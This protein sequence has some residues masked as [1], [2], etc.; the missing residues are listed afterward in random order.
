M[1]L[2]GERYKLKVCAIYS[3]GQSA[4]SE[5]VIWQYEPCD[6]WGPV[7]EVTLDAA[8]EGNHLAWVFEHGHNQ[9][10]DPDGGDEPTPTP[11]DEVTVTLSYPEAIWSD[12]SGYQMLLDADATAYGNE[13]PT[14]GG[15]TTSGNAPAGL[16]DAFEYKIPANADG[17]MTTSNIVAPGNSVTIVIPAGTYDWCITNPTPGDRIWIAS[18]NGNVGGRQDDY[19]FEAGRTY[20][21]VLSA[22]GTNDGVDVTISNG[23]RNTVAPMPCGE[24]KVNSVVPNSMNITFL[25]D[26]PVYR[27]YADD[28][29][30][31]NFMGID[32]IDF[33]AY[34]LYNITKDERFSLIPEADYGQ[35]VLTS[36][37]EMD[38]FVEEVES[39]Y[40]S[41]KHEFDMLSKN[42]IFEHMTEW[43]NAVDPQNFLS[44]TM[45]VALNNSRTEND[46]CIVSLPFCTTDLVEFEAASTDNT[47]DEQGMDDGCIGYSYNP[48]WYHMRIHDAGPFVIHMEAIAANPGDHMDVD[49]CMWG[50]YTEEEVTSGYACTHLTSDKIMD[51][52]YS[53]DQT[54]DV[55]LG[56]PEGQHV[57]GGIGHGSINYHMP[58]VGEY[59]ILMLT[60]YSRN[61]CTISFTKTEGE[62]ETDCDIVT[63][64]NIIGF[65]ITQDG[66]YLDIVGPDVRDYTH[67]G[68]FGEHEY[69]VRPIYPGPQILSDTNYYFSMGCPICTNTV[70]EDPCVTNAILVTADNPWTE[71]FEDFHY[72]EGAS[73]YSTSINDSKAKRMDADCWDVSPVYSSLAQNTHVA[74]YTDYQ[75]ASFSGETSVQF[76]N[77]NN[78]NGTVLILP[79]F[80][81][82]MNQLQFSFKSCYWTL[83]GNMQVG[84]WYEGQFMSLYDD[85]PITNERGN[86]E[87]G[88]YTNA[89][90]AASGPFTF[91]GAP[92]GSR[93]AIRYYSSSS[94]GCVNLDDFSVSVLSEST[95]VDEI[96]DNVNLFPNPTKGNVTIQAKGMSRITVVSVLGQV[97]FDTELDQDEYILNMAQ[98]TTGMYMVRIYTDEGVT[99][100]RVTVMK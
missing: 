100:K 57:H 84:Y 79:P 67:V 32:N 11:G 5:A 31:L 71:N 72:I 70:V 44:I 13:I 12:G 77:K 21:F 78:A 2:E 56:Y 48:S 8:N 64:T 33:R 86:D 19:V 60:N 14:S 42:D 17:N 91:E 29:V 40:E 82:A 37:Y 30:M 23:G 22:Y 96:S 50:P 36:A 45:D 39:F 16:Y 75:P 52:C 66:E 55:Y 38:N 43:K 92:E 47:A 87:W 41:N 69:C 94:S 76:W 49:F 97:V 28:G 63:P 93:I 4:W 68:E 81:N 6:H 53:G 9:W 24:V 61:P 18:A 98:F 35:F 83:A 89:T 80:A 59:Y 62:G 95:G 58:Q 74:L 26:E 88:S 54:E 34:L 46:H 65:L 99:V 7:D 1:L 3:T 20:E 15:L 27:Q 90:G 10:F 51:C 25:Q 73:N 85:V